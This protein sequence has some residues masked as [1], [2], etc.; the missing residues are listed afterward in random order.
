LIDVDETIGDLALEIE[1]IEQED[2][3][4]IAGRK[5]RL[6]LRETCILVRRYR[7]AVKRVL[8]GDYTWNG[9]VYLLNLRTQHEH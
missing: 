4:T 1:L 7:Q 2:W 5:L 9:D 3:D 8:Y 6:Q